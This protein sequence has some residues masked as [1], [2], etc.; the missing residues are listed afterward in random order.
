MTIACGI[1]Y[2]WSVDSGGLVGVLFSQ[3]NI[4]VKVHDTYLTVKPLN[5][6]PAETIY[7]IHVKISYSQ[8]SVFLTSWGSG[9]GCLLLGP[10]C[11]YMWS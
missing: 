8:F 2:T 3:C 4:S 1:L 9:P 10:D 5:T 6:I 7:A 11:C